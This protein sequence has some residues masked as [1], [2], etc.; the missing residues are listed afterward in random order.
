V[1]NQPTTWPVDRLVSCEQ[2]A[3]Q[4]FASQKEILKYLKGCGYKIEKSALSNHVR[5]GLLKMKGGVWRLSDV[6]SYAQLNLQ[7]AGTGQTAADKRTA[8]LMERKLRADI[9]RTEELATK[10]RL[11]REVLEGKFI[12][13]ADVELELAGRAVVLDAGVRGMIKAKAPAW[14]ELVGGAQGRLPD[15][16][17]AMVNDFFGLLNDYATT[18]RFQVVFKKNDG[19]I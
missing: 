8:D 9:M 14:I 13:R 15:M 12:S 4:E 1:T 11:E 7:G 6:D 18:E 10:A 17:E 2:E 5:R 16:I 3:P 19:G